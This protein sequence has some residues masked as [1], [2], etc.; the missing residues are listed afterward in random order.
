LDDVQLTLVHPAGNCD[1]HKPERI[2]SFR[3]VGNP[4]MAARSAENEVFSIQSDPIFGPRQR[5]QFVP[6]RSEKRHW[7]HY[8]EWSAAIS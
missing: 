3:H 7:Q 5:C 4:I 1:P 6:P 8:A 2:P